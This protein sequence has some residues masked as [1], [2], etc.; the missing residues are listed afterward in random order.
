MEILAF[1]VRP[2]VGLAP[3]LIKD[4]TNSHRS[5]TVLIKS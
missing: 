5:P 4:T 1:I 2:N 3:P